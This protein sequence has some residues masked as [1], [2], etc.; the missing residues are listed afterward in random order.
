MTHPSVDDTTDP[1]LHKIAF[2]SNRGAVDP[3][4]A[5]AA[6]KEM[7]GKGMTPED[8]EALEKKLRAAKKYL[9]SKSPEEVE[10]LKVPAFLAP[11]VEEESDEDEDEE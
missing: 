3:A 8:I 6:A 10:A 9:A 5:E 4:E 7:L 2:F 1:T 11:P